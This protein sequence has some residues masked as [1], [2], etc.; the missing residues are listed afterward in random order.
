MKKTFAIVATPINV[1]YS[2][3][4]EKGNTHEGTTIYTVAVEHRDNIP[5]KLKVYKTS[6]EFV[7]SCCSGDIVDRL[8][9]DEYGRLVGVG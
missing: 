1:A 9:F 7:A 6:P 5:V 4:D 3:K 2:F 8:F